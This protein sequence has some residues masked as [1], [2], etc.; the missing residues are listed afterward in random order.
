MHLS[1]NITFC[2]VSDLKCG[3]RIQD[4]LTEKTI[5]TSVERYVKTEFVRIIVC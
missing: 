4:R 2:I 3:K 5:C 1:Y